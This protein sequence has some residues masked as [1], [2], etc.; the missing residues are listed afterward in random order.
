MKEWFT[1]I[2]TSVNLLIAHNGREALNYL[3]GENEMP[4]IIFLDINMPVLD[5]QKTLEIIK[6]TPKLKNIYVIVLTLQDGCFTRKYAN[7]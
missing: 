6:S 1:Q 5:G 3:L 2:D 4:D 7:N